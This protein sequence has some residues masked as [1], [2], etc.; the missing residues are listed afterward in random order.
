MT[1]VLYRE[2]SPWGVW[3][4][5]RRWG[6]AHNPRTGLATALANV[7]PDIDANDQ[8]RTSQ[9]LGIIQEVHLAP[10]ADAVYTLFIVACE[11]VDGAIPYA[12]LE[13][14]AG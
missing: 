11:T 7:H 6:V 10:K 2:P 5:E 8:G 4:G 14:Y 12:A 13:D 9:T 3:A 1:E